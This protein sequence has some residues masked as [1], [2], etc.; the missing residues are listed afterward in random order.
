MIP[1]E[2]VDDLEY[3]LQVAEEDG[4]IVV[5]F[6]GYMQSGKTTAAN[7]LVSKYGF[8]KIAMAQELK[9]E[10][11]QILALF[12]MS[13]N[14]GSKRIPDEDKC[15]GMA[16]LDP[17]RVGKIWER[18]SE[19]D[20]LVNE[21]LKRFDDTVLKR[22]YRLMLQWW[23]TEYR[24]EGDVNYWVQRWVEKVG[25]RKG[26]FVID[27]VRFENEVDMVKGYFDGVIVRIVR[28]SQNIEDQ[29]GSGHASENPDQ[30]KMDGTVC[31]YEGRIDGMQE[32]LEFVLTQSILEC[33]IFNK[34]DCNQ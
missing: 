6:T 30:L 34:N 31:N 22:K 33:K 17:C 23:G 25:G 13:N 29:V 5:G 27:D 32:D 3:V 26:R 9:V 15:D 16:L 14:L 1:K 4:P 7:H 8:K 18:K 12:D 21:Y 10:V 11:A 28:P 20:A 19:Y 24:R 2:D